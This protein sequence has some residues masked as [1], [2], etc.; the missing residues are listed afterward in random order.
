MILT[1]G[2]MP[3]SV[4]SAPEKNGLAFNDSHEAATA[5]DVLAR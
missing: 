5:L 3:V 2:T 1:I 4:R